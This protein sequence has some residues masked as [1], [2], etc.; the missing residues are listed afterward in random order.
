[1][2]SIATL[3]R[4]SS[5][6]NSALERPSP[7]LL[8]SKPHIPRDGHP[9]AA[10]PKQQRG[11]THPHGRDSVCDHAST[12]TSTWPATIPEGSGSASSCTTASESASSCTTASG[13]P[14]MDVQPSDAV[15]G[16]S[17]CEP[18]SQDGS[19]PLSGGC[20]GAE[21]LPS[22]T[23]LGGSIS[24]SQSVA[25]STES[26]RNP[27]ESSDR[28]H[29][30]VAVGRPPPPRIRH[31]SARSRGG[32]MEAFQDADQSALPPLRILVAEDNKVSS[33]LNLVV[34]NVACVACVA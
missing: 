29:S 9:G 13:S 12:G 14:C 10:T 6:D 4:R 15:E 16:G 3:W 18:S 11:L 22:P 8:P 23:I 28:A 31:Y 27:A 7:P 20:Q 33:L 2:P 5:L 17:V 24:C 32:A 26:T 19:P 1:M 34:L 25:H 21:R 30:R